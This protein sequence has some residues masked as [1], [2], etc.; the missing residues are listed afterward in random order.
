MEVMSGKSIAQYTGYRIQEKTDNGR[1]ERAKVGAQCRFKEKTI[2]NDG[3][4]DR[5]SDSQLPSD[6]KLIARPPRV[7]ASQSLGF[8]IM[9]FMSSKVIK[10]PYGMRLAP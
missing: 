6:G 3:V 8:A 9:L 4:A 2:V 1:G 7:A 5:Y 10:H